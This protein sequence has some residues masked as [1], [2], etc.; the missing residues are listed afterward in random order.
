MR[1][2][3]VGTSGE[4]VRRWQTFLASKGYQVGVDSQFG[5][6][7][8]NATVQFQADHGLSTDGKVG[9]DTYMKAAELGFVLIDPEPTPEPSA[10]FS[11]IRKTTRDGV[12]L[13]KFDSGD[14]VFFKANMAVDA[15]GCPLTY[16]PNNTG[17][18]FNANS[19]GLKPSIIAFVNGHPYVQTGADP[20]PGYY[21]SKTAWTNPSNPPVQ[22]TS[23]YLDSLKVSYVVI[24]GG[25]IGGAKTGNAA[26]VIDLHNGN[27][28]SAVVGDVGPTQ[29]A[30]EA[31]MFLCGLVAGK[32]PSEINEAFARKPGSASNPKNGGFD[33][34]RFRYVVFLRVFVPWGSDQA[35]MDSIGE[36]AWNALTEAQ[37]AVLTA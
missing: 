32:Q 1:L 13:F 36:G 25:D 21:V 17:L 30:G 2:L 10:D 16:H 18:D 9:H 7:T 5:T 12:N 22:S 26:V 14:A 27:R 11:L 6:E 8:K 19:G 34:D 23:R 20:A 3:K 37:R 33:D 15:D 28:F 24:P 29:S 31:S 35:T 4:D